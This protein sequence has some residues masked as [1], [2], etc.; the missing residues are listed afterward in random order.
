[1]KV[2][3]DHYAFLLANIAPWAGQLR[4]HRANLTARKEKENIKDIEKRLRWDAMY[5]ANLSRY[6][7]DT[8][9]TYCDDTHVDTALRS[10]MRE[11]SI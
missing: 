1:M 10:I 11:L 4:I 6:A 7:C 2:Q 9:Y 5:A 3:T 8:L